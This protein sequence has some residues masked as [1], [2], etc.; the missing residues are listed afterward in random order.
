MRQM[1]FAVRISC[2]KQFRDI[3][4]LAIRDSSTRRC[5]L[6]AELMEIIAACL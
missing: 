4:P 5:V 2:G 3:I 1:I 6:D